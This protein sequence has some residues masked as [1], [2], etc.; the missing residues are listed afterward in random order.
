MLVREYS[1][2]GLTDT[3]K[4][5]GAGTLGQPPLDAAL[6]NPQG[7]LSVPRSVILHFLYIEAPTAIRSTNQDAQTAYTQILAHP[8]GL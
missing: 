6:R 8:P 1:P 2:I 5:C 3:R 7:Y 4:S